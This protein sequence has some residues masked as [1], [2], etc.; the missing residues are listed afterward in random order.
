MNEKMML[1]YMCKYTR[2]V[3]GRLTIPDK[4]RVMMCATE[5]IFL[6]HKAGRN[7]KVTNQPKANSETRRSTKHRKK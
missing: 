6:Y 5:L 4:L 2:H 3:W 1:T 7:G